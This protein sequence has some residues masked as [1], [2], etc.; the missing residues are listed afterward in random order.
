MHSWSLL[1]PWLALYACVVSVAQP[2]NGTR[3]VC[4]YTNW[5]VYRPGTA[6]FSPQ[7]INPYLCTHLI[8]AFGG[9]TR[10]NGL[11]PYDKYQDIEQGGY[12]KF[13]GLKTYN[14]QLKTMLAIGGWN[15]GS[16]RFSPLVAD[17]ERRAELVHNTVRFLRQN[18][19][20][21]L[22]L[23]WEYPAFRDGGKPRDRENYALLVQ[24]L[25]TEFDRESAKT[26]RPRLLLTMAVPAGI[27]YIDKGYDIP[28]L[29]RYLDFM[30][31]LSY[32]YHSAFEPAVNHHSPLYPLEEDSEYNFDSQLSIDYTMEHYVKLGADRDKLVLGI[33][34][35]GRSYTLFNPIATEIGSPADGPGEQGDATR[36]KGYLAYYEICENLKTADWKIEH[37]NP[38]AMGPYAYKGNQWVGYDDIDIVKLKARYVRENGLGGIMFWAIDNDDFRGKCHGR[39]YP[40]IEAGKEALLASGSETSNDVVSVTS[41]RG[42]SKA[43]HHKRPVDRSSSVT[44][45]RNIGSG[46]GRQGPQSEPR[47]HKRR[48]SNRRHHDKPIRSTTVSTTTTTSTTPAYNYPQTT[49]EPPTTPDPGSDFMCKDEGFFPHPRD[50]KKYFWCL[51]SGPSN[52]GIV[53]HQFTCPSGLFFN[54]GADSCDYA[55][56]VVCKKKSG[57]T[58]T[59]APPITA[60]TSRTTYISSSTASTTTT[61]TTTTAKS[62]TPEEEEEEEEY[63]DEEYEDEED[64]EEDPQAIKDLINLIKKLGGIEQLEKQLH[65]QDSDQGSPSGPV[66]TSGFSRSLYDRVLNRNSNRANS[67]ASDSLPTTPRY[68]SLY[69]NRPVKPQNEGLEGLDEVKA[70]RREKPQYV[71]IKRNRPST[72][73]PDDEEEEEEE[74]EEGEV[75]QE[76]AVPFAREERNKADDTR[77]VE[78]VTIRRSRPTGVVDTDTT[79]P[80]YITIQRSRKPALE[81]EQRTERAPDSKV[82]IVTEMQDEAES[83]TEEPEQKVS[84][85]YPQYVDVASIGR[86]HHSP[87]PG[88]EVEKTDSA[89]SYPEVNSIDRRRNIIHMIE[90]LDSSPSSTSTEN[91]PQYVDVS[92]IRKHRV[93]TL[94]DATINEEDVVTSRTSENIDSSLTDRVSPI[95]DYTTPET[96]NETIW[97]QSL[98]SRLELDTLHLASTTPLTIVESNIQDSTVQVTVPPPTSTKFTPTVT[99]VITS[100]TESGTTERQRIAVNRVPYLA[101]AALR[102]ETV[103]PGT[104]STVT[105]TAPSTT[106]VTTEHKLEK[107]MEVNRITLVT[108]KEDL[109]LPY[110]KAMSENV[111]TERIQPEK[112]VDK[113]SEV[114]RLKLVTV[115]GGNQTTDEVLSTF[116][117]LPSY[118][119][120]TTHHGNLTNI[121][122]EYI[123]TIVYGTENI[124]PVT[125]P[126][127]PEKQTESMAA[128]IN[129]P[130]SVEL[131]PSSVRPVSYRLN[132]GADRKPVVDEFKKRRFRPTTSS[133]PEVSSTQSILP[134]KR[135]GQLKRPIPYRRTTTKEVDEAVILPTEDTLQISTKSDQ[136]GFVP[137]RN[138][139]RRPQLRRTSTLTTASANEDTEKS[140]VVITENPS[141]TTFHFV[142]KRGGREKVTTQKSTTETITRATET[143]KDEI[144]LTT[145]VKEENNSNE[146][147]TIDAIDTTTNTIDFRDHIESSTRD[148]GI[149]QTEN[150]SEFISKSKSENTTILTT[151]NNG[152]TEV[153]T[154]AWGTTSNAILSST[155]TWRE[156]AN[157]ETVTEATYSREQNDK[158]TSTGHKTRQNTKVHSTGQSDSVTKTTPGVG[159]RDR[160]RIKKR[161]RRPEVESSVASTTE[162]SNSTSDNKFDLQATLNEIDKTTQDVEGTSFATAA[163]LGR[164][165]YDVSTPGSVGEFATVVDREGKHMVMISILNDPDKPQ[166]PI[167]NDSDLNTDSSGYVTGGAARNSIYTLSASVKSTSEEVSDGHVTETVEFPK[168]E[169]TYKSSEATV[170]A[171]TRQ[172]S[173]NYFIANVDFTTASGDDQLAATRKPV[174]N[175]NTKKTSPDGKRRRLVRRKRPSSTTEVQSEV[176]TITT[177]A[178]TTTTTATRPL[179]RPTGSLFNPNRVRQRPTTTITTTT[180]AS[181]S[182]TASSQLTRKPGARVVRR[183]KYG[184]TTNRTRESNSA[185][186]EYET[187]E[188]PTIA[189]S[190]KDNVGGSLVRKYNFPRRRTT[191]PSSALTTIPPPVTTTPPIVTTVPPIITTLPPPVDVPS[192]D[193]QLLESKE[194]QANN[195]EAEDELVTTKLPD[196]ANAAVVAIHNLAT[197]APVTSVIKSRP[198][199]TPPHEN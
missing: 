115:S 52:L 14:K 40:L 69:R 41:S 133:K 97:T 123:S 111:S 88:F 100:V 71:T 195:A 177:T 121:Q 119:S 186:S 43:G 83:R 27:E 67:P 122:D 20:D 152:I 105:F 183:R 163:L 76:A 147:L 193:M 15:E 187:S 166:L 44:S 145:S 7:N 151:I 96:Q 12:A 139:R 54:K 85:A 160:L 161:R 38:R 107:V 72:P 8:Y 60:A 5:S 101:I 148:S 130:T 31:I 128:I 144:G 189:A 117:S 42:K 64:A 168:K 47:P 61:T 197:T 154:K 106:A 135:R 180:E 53:A 30:N 50:C 90:L 82:L 191:I 112:T 91:H 162:K 10:E 86:R 129:E 172:Q 49:P 104:Q 80:R 17:E 113:V 16:T 62:T 179:R 33:P 58:T 198:T 56:N 153:S 176:V 127:I 109:P 182:S 174:T 136:R 190:D 175:R 37:P 138:Q 21:G 4:Y 116:S 143:Q 29:N 159:Q 48:P 196:L 59:K 84:G 114:S 34:T 39:P 125:E 87:V 158:D 178:A 1:V 140:V 26:G 167:T 63:D 93:T 131:S 6:K 28:K 18:H 169:T 36:E 77:P 165:H 66:T 185:I 11:R 103:Y 157:T 171:S 45:S 194:Y 2:Q 73:E 124:I 65:L 110:T 120:E 173:K 164:N 46:S 68:T 94:S 57:S 146:I 25:R 3:V 181:T 98:D 81:P 141:N 32:D 89:L 192:G 70:L 24:E 199:T 118:P 19:F 9:L 13:T 156:T 74:E 149:S 78:Y 95:P 102:G 92:R 35:Y 108:V 132:Q 134:K 51:D 170:R 137:K 99:R 75:K 22:D 184:P 150:K 188:S 23:D 155:D 79:T 126:Y 142:P 55:R